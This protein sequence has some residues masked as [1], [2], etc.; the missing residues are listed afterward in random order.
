[1]ILWEDIVSRNQKIKSRPHA[2]LPFG[3]ANAH[4]I[5]QPAMAHV[6]YGLIGHACIVYSDDIVIYGHTP[7][8]LHANL[9]AVLQ[10]L[11]DTGLQLKPSK[12]HI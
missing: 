6:L 8:E 9:R 5:F 11:K 3:L 1:M 2:R 12:C 10:C 7:K 4:A